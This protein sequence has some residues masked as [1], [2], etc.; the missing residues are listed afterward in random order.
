MRG[1]RL[2]A[3]TIVFVA[4]FVVQGGTTFAAEPAEQL[5]GCGEESASGF[6]LCLGYEELSIDGG[7][8]TILPYRLLDSHPVAKANYHKPLGDGLL[9][10]SF[11]YEGEDYYNFTGNFYGLTDTVVVRS[12]KF[13]KN[14]EHQ[15]LPGPF[16]TSGSPLYWSEDMDPGDAYNM[17]QQEHYASFKHKWRNYPANVSVAV[18]QY[19]SEG[20]KQQMFLNENC[21][22]NCHTVS[23]TRSVKTTTDQV[24]LNGTTHMGPVDVSF[25]FRGTQFTD[26]MPDPVYAFGDISSFSGTRDVHNTYPDM[27]SSEQLLSISTNHTGRFSGLLG[28]GAGDRENMDSGVSETYQQLLGRLL[29]RPNTKVAV[30]VDSKQL[31]QQDDKPPAAVEAVRLAD[32][33]PLRYGSVQNR[34]KVTVN[35]YPMSKMDLKGTFVLTDTEREDNELWGLPD[36]TSSNEWSLTARIKPASKV[37]IKAAYSDRT[38]DNPAYQSSPTDSHKMLLSGQWIPLSGLCLDADLKDFSDENTDNGQTNDRQILGAGITYTPPK[39]FS[40]AFRVYQFTNDIS[41]DITF[42]DTAPSP[43]TDEDV[44]YTAE[45]TQYMLQAVWSATKKLQVTGQYSYLQAEGSYD[46][47]TTGFDDVEGYSG[48]DATQQESFLDLNY[49]MNDGWGVSAR[50]AQLSYEDKQSDLADEDIS[51]VSAS[52]TRRW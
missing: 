50:L 41:A 1:K 36:D 10:I 48:L 33:A 5:E 46:A 4:L 11:S 40:L 43:I 8:E 6:G 51:E 21:A 2:K 13:V 20:E 19:V 17:D 14:M 49:T 26:D 28:L 7:G 35:Y 42:A 47:D 25:H 44:P 39:P 24:F 9:G 22:T 31:Y 52:V 16:D 32:G 27:D 30:F 29:W 37:K 38:T 34:H 12:Q 45:G 15:N 23:Q 3:L 18:R